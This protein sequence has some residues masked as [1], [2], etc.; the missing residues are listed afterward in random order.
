MT[1]TTEIIIEPD[2]MVLNDRGEYILD[3]LLAESERGMVLIAGTFID[4]HL[5]LLLRGRFTQE[6]IEKNQQNKLLQG[7]RALFGSGWAK[8]TAGRAFGLIGQREYI[9]LCAVRHIRNKCAHSNFRITLADAELASSM[10]ALRDYLANS[11]MG[12]GTN[13]P[14]SPTLALWRFTL[15]LHNIEPDEMSSNAH[16]FVGA[17]ITLLFKFMLKGMGVTLRDGK[18]LRDL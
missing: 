14:S 4:N 16:I 2:P 8:E 11:D 9:A 7:D 17:V 18:F 12:F 15:K 3:A 1:D 10:T 13:N 5:E 6:G